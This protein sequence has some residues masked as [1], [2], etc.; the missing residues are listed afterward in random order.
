MF[1]AQ[2]STGDKLPT[3][4]P[5]LCSLIAAVSLFNF[6]PS[7]HAQMYKW[8]GPNGKIVYSDTP[9]PANA[10]KLGTKAFDQSASISNI[11]LPPDLAAAVAKNPVT[12][13]ATASCG[14]CNEARNMLKKNGIPFFEKTISNPEDLEKLKQVSGDTQLPFMLINKAKFAGFESTE[15]RSALSSAGYPEQSI[16]PKDY[17]YPDPEPAAPPAPSTAKKTDDTPKEVPRPK[18]TSPTGIRF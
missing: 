17:R 4:L 16:L 12:F 6:V 3:Y 5:M 10:K 1:V 15:W 8:V 11:K 7:A 2:K 13:Y 18:S 9:P 14:V